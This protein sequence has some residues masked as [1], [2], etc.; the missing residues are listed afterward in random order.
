MG[1]NVTGGIRQAWRGP[2][3][4]LMH[5]RVAVSVWRYFYIYI[6]RGRERER[7]RERE[8]ETE[9]RGMRL[10]RGIQIVCLLPISRG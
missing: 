2:A 5:C 9:R 4:V 1:E 10:L 7:E 6:E 8:G 3:R